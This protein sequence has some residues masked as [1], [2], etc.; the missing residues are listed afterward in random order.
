VLKHLIIVFLSFFFLTANSQENYWQQRVDYQIDVKLDT[1]T[2]S[3]D[4]FF[5]MNYF[6]NSPD[7]LEYIWMHLMP[8]A[9]KTDQTAFSE[10]FLSHGSV[11]FYFSD[12]E[13]RGYIHRLNFESEGRILEI[14]DHPEHIDII[15]LHLQQPLLPGGNVIISTPFRVKLP[16]LFSRLG[17]S[18]PE[19]AIAHWYPVPAMYDKEGWHPMPYLDIGEFYAP[20]GK[21]NVRISVPDN[22]KVAATGKLI[23]ET[24]AELSADIP[25]GYKTLHFMQDSVHA[26]AWFASEEYIINR[27]S[28][29]LPS[30]KII[31]VQVF[32]YESSH[33]S[34]KHAME[35]AK[36]ALLF[37]SDLT[38]E[39]PYGNATI[40]AAYDDAGGG[41]EYP[42]ITRLGSGGNKKILDYIIEHELGHNW[43]YGILATNERQHP[44]MDEG[45]NSYYDNRYMKEK[46]GTA[47]IYLK[48]NPDSK[49]SK[50]PENENEVFVNA[51]ASVHADQPMDLPAD[52]YSLIN[53]SLIVYNKTALWLEKLEELMGR[54][55][56]DRAMKTYYETWKFKHPYPEDFKK[57]IID[58]G[59]PELEEHFQLLSRKGSLNSTSKKRIKPVV[60]GSL[61]Q[62]DKY[63]YINILPLP[64]YNSYDKF[65]AGA[66]IHN[67]GLPLSKL[68]FAILPQYGFGSKKIN[69]S[70]TINYNHFLS[71]KFRKLTAGINSSSYSVNS[72]IDSA[73]TAVYA[74]FKKIVPFIKL[75]FNRHALSRKE[76]WV[77]FK[78]FQIAEKDLDYVMR[79]SDSTYHARESNYK[80]RYVNE[81]KFYYA[82]HR[83]LYPWGAEIK[84]HQAKDFYRADAELNYFFNYA[85]GGGLSFRLFASKFGLL[86][87]GKTFGTMRYQ[88]KLTAVRGW[89]DY[90]YSNTFFG[91][92]E[93][94]GFSSRQI[95]G[96]DGNLKIR[97]DIFQGLQGRSDNWIAAINLNTTLPEKLFPV[98]LPLSVFFD[99]G[100]FAE[101]WDKDYRDARFMYVAGLRL[102]LLKD[103]I[104]IYAPLLMSKTFKDNMNTVPETKGFGNRIS[105]TL[106]VYKLNFRKLNKGSF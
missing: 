61:Y 48:S 36:S 101:A 12:D 65:M 28:L 32:Y 83:V 11:D 53:Y 66:L 47:N 15:K 56:F 95:M 25:T 99:A 79:H 94:D 75:E 78:T 82:D 55:S 93:T 91:R 81:L 77:E 54:E 20:F 44:W 80:H 64:G 26:F 22:M 30:G 43:F 69:Y 51:L 7:T 72:A 16:K 90:T 92:N 37:R 63:H 103:V 106:D 76:A 9:F 41:M 23:E 31:D 71:G 97:T 13:E 68:R 96:R 88:P 62:T 29:Q 6:N 86:G 14:S 58:E 40:V 24:K 1:A 50:L 42:T 67:Y 35:F 34:W 49:K 70:G 100:T 60:F 87:S 102:S 45:I 10:Q 33:E 105:F 38:G 3:L 52:E 4:A 73:G 98:K 89:E 59:G 8:N 85:K 19:Y 104:E 18:G 5:V 57:I 17:V 84:F 27:D 2:N 74:S 21:W 46:Y 39:Y